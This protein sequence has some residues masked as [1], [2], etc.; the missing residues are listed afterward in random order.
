MSLIPGESPLVYAPS[1]GDRQHVPFLGVADIELL[2][3][4]EFGLQTKLAASSL[5]DAHRSPRLR[6]WVR[7]DLGLGWALDP[8]LRL[9]QL[10]DD[11][12]NSRR[13][14]DR[15]RLDDQRAFLGEAIGGAD[16][17]GGDLTHVGASEIAEAFLD[18]ERNAWATALIVP[19]LAHLDLSPRV[20]RNN[21]ALLEAAIDYFHAQGLDAVADDQGSFAKSR[22]LF[23]GVS[24]HAKLLRDERFVRYLRDAYSELSKHL[25]GY[26]VQIP[27]LTSGAPPAVIRGLS[28]FVYPLQDEVATNVVLDRVGPFGLGYLANGIAGDCMGTGAPEF[29]TH[30]P[31]SY[32]RQ[33]RPGEDD[34]G[35]ALVVYNQVLLRN[36]QMS[37]RHGLRGQLAYR[38]HPCGDCGSHDRDKAPLGNRAKKLHGFFW[39]R[40]Q[41]REL[42]VGVV[43]E[44][45]R[46]FLHMLRRAQQANAELG[47]DGSYYEALRVTM[48]P[49]AA[50]G[51]G[52][53]R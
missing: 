51:F 7:K 52:D 11:F 46:R 19:A 30:P 43:P 53:P 34:P 2:A 35:F 42:C 3:E 16:L 29:I 14:V 20:L 28:D 41:T 6:Q 47:E 45:Q 1:V 44:T 18:V 25:Y 24:I 40:V 33:L 39:H 12:I 31:S 4:A 9:L 21:L 32:R 26:W 50:V 13:D 10:D 37:G 17:L 48:R 27:Q 49:E 22:Q 8:Q 23:A 38:R 5:L 36:R 15:Q